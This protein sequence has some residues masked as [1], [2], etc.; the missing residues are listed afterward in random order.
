M[1]PA[2]CALGCTEMKKKKKRL[3]LEV[4]WLSVFK[5]CVFHEIL[6]VRVVKSVAANTLN[7]L[8]KIKAG[9]V[10][11]LLILKSRLLASSRLVYLNRSASLRGQA[12]Y[13]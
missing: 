11:A 6:L 8:Y 1:L 13:I 4:I 7:P 12:C 2:L 5:V 3:T 9:V 10:C